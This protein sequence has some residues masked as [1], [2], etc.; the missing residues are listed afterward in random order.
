MKK[1]IFLIALAACLITL[2]IAGTSLAYF[3]DVKTQSTV[4]T[5]GNVGIEL[6]YTGLQTDEKSF[7]GVSH[8]ISAS[9]TNTG[10][11]DAYVGAIIE[12]TQSNLGNIL[13]VEAGTDN[14]PS[15][16][17]EFLVNLEGT[18]KIVKYAAT[19][20]GYTVYVVFETPVEA[21]TTSTKNSVNIFD[22]VAIPAEWG[23]DQ[24]AAFMGLKVTVTA[25]AT[26]T[27]G[28]GNNS[29]A[30]GALTTAFSNWE[31]YA[32]ANTAET[33]AENVEEND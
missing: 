8:N 26:Q 32:A 30:A 23:N 33:E 7:P 3:T 11:E 12:L 19:A 14:I 9:I 17:S 4:F 27:V 24:M 1:K 10:T 5:A 31:G 15:A 6:N 13:A 25:Y 16:I 2:S 18:G 22:K 20:S 21:T 28:F 29:D